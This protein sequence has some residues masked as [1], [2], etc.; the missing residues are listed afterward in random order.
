MDNNITRD[1][2]A[3]YL[4][5]EFGLT[6][7]D[8]NDLVNDIIET[9]IEGLIDNKIVKIHNFGT[10][11]LKRKNSRLGRNPKTKEEVIIS[12]RNVITFIPSK[13]I[14][15]KLNENFNG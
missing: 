5:Q 13:N 14:L 9:I 1:D 10:F 4:N 3:D 8:C 2:I 15:K 7:K 6:K 12:E 11:K